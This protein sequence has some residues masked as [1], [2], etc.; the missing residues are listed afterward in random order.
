MLYKFTIHL[1]PQTHLGLS[2]SFLQRVR[3]FISKVKFYV[4]I[5]AQYLLCTTGIISMVT[6]TRFDEAGMVV[7]KDKTVD[8]V[9]DH[10]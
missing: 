2:R 7:V 8:V 3:N 4:T 5:A 9:R 1:L 6:L 10:C